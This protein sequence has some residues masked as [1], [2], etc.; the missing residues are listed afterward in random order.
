MA[1]D[2]DAVG[3]GDSDFI[4]LGGLGDGGGVEQGHGKIAVCVELVTLSDELWNTAAPACP[5]QST[6]SL[7]CSLLAMVT[8]HYR[9]RT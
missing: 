9:R 4:A 6:L 7:K 8:F 1:L 5:A 2:E 3:A